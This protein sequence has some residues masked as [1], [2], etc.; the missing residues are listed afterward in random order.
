MESRSFNN[1]SCTE[2]GARDQ[3]LKTISESY[4]L[5][6]GRSILTE[7]VVFICEECGYFSRELGEERRNY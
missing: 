5:R 2:C 3:K 7:E 6:E 4:D 1:V